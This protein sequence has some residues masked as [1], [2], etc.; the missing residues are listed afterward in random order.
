MTAAERKAQERRHDIESPADA[1]LH[2]WF[3]VANA[4][5][6]RAYVQRTGSPGHD[7]ARAWE[8]E[9]ARHKGATDRRRTTRRRPT[10]PPMPRATCW[11]G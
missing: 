1:W 11:R 5:R 6:A 9:A 2:R 10:P 3:L 4:S 8:D 7:E